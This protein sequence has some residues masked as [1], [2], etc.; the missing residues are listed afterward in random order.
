MDDTDEHQ[1]RELHAKS[2]I[3]IKTAKASTF[4]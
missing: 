2:E 4:Q 1:Q 3:I